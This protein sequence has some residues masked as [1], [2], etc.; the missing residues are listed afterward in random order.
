M[1]KDIR[2][3]LHGDSGLDQS[4]PYAVSQNMSSPPAWIATASRMSGTDSVAHDARSDG[5]GKRSDMPE[6]YRSAIG[7]RAAVSE[8]LSNCAAGPCRQWKHICSPRL[9]CR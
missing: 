6:K 9:A 2:D 7:D 3:L 8:V 4:A 5:F 1:S